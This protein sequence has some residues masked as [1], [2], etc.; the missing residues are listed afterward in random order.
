MPKRGL[1]AFGKGG[2]EK[3]Y[4]PEYTSKK[5]GKAS[6][7]PCRFLHRFNS[8]TESA[9]VYFLSSILLKIF[10]SFREF[11]STLEEWHIAQKFCML[12]PFAV[13]TLRYL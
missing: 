11:G 7:A 12:A 3:S 2:Q 1:P 8:G 4:K 10:T 5:T 9:A 13:S 6:Y